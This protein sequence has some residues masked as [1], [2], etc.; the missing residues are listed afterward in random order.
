ME[1]VLYPIIDV[2]IVDETVSKEKDFVL[3]VSMTPGIIKDNFEPLKAAL[4]EEMEQYQDLSVYQGDDALKDMKKSRVKLNN[5][6]KDVKA[7]AKRQKDAY[8][9]PL[10]EFN[11]R[12]SE[13]L[14]IIDEPKEQ[15]DKE[16]KD[17]EELLRKEQKV[18]IQTFYETY[19]STTGLCMES[20]KDELFD[21]IFSEKWLN[22]STTQKTWKT[23]IQNAVTKYLENES[24]LVS[25]N[26]PDYFPDALKLLQETLDVTEA[27]AYINKKKKAAEEQ[28]RIKMQAEARA[29]ARMEQELAR[30]KKE[31]EE[32]LLRETQEALELEKQRMQSEFAAASRRA[33]SH[34]A[35]HV[36]CN[37]DRPVQSMTE[38]LQNMDA[39]EYCT[40]KIKKADYEKAIAI[41]TK[42]RIWFQSDLEK[43]VI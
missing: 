37:M 39:P 6:V 11:K 33:A 7:E 25:M 27:V 19:V 32:R 13:F 41:L 40:L 3:N 42:Y 21:K 5:L 35:D 2:D 17:Q 28:E 29:Q 30:A 1:N 34:P 18:K 31:Q 12:V 15:L 20:F 26:E 36:Q 10:V 16:I 4:I 22:S 14:E 43:K 9:K 8:N 23:A 38:A 24:L